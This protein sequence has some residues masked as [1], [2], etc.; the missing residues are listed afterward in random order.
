MIHLVAGQLPP[1]NEVRESEE[2]ENE[3][4]AD[5]MLNEIVRGL[6]SNLLNTFKSR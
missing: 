2:P 4:S 6:T 3:E 5:D 1:A